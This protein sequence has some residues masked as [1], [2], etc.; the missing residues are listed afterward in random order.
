MTYDDAVALSQL[1]AIE[2]AVPTL[3]VSN[4]F[5]G[6]RISVKGGG[7]VL[8]EQLK[9]KGIDAA[10]V[11]IDPLET[12]DADDLTPDYYERKVRQNVERLANVLK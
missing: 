11:E 12:A 5:F 8:L 3:S 6:R 7:K 9:R 1:P 2:L 4:D 10:F